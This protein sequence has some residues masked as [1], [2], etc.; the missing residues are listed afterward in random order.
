ME[1]ALLPA[2]SQAGRGHGQSHQ[3][4]FP[5]A[6]EQP[7]PSE[8][9]GLLREARGA[10]GE[11]LGRGVG[12]TQAPRQWVSADVP[13]RQP[14][15]WTGPNC[16]CSPWCGWTCSCRELGT[17]LSSVPCDGTVA[18]AASHPGQQGFCLEYRKHLGRNLPETSLLTTLLFRGPCF[19]Y[20]DLR[21]LRRGSCRPPCVCAYTVPYEE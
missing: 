19:S 9:Q 16:E 13:H 5:P 6:S 21:I 2:R 4:G 10:A 8:V 1:P 3:S 18:L 20:E 11:N 14:S 15:G 12:H 17:G 7:A